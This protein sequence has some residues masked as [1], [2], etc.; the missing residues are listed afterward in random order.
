MITQ[1]TY[2]FRQ[3]TKQDTLLTAELVCLQKSTCLQKSAEA[4]K[5]Q[6]LGNSLDNGNNDCH[7]YTLRETPKRALRR[8][9]AFEIVKGN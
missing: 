9:A 1:T 8:K 4:E 7:K 6:V 5:E 3:N 2:P